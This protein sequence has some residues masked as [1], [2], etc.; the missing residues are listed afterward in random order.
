MA[1]NRWLGQAAPVAQVVTLTV[2]S[3]TAGHTFQTTINGKTIEYV[4]GSGETTTTIAT[5]IQALLAAS[6]APEF[7]EVTWTSDGA[8]VTGTAVTAGRP[9]TVTEAGT[10]TYTLATATASSGP[11]HVDLAANWSEGALPSADGTDDILIDGPAPDLLWGWENVPSTAYASVKILA[12]F[13]GR[14]GLPYRNEEGGYVE[15]R[16]R[17]F[18]LGTA[19]PVTIGE[20]DGGGPGLVNLT[21]TTA[22]DVTVLA[23]GE[24]AVPSTPAV[25]V[26]GMGS[27]TVVVVAG[28]VGVATDDSTKFAT[29]TTATVNDGASLAVGPGATVTTL[30][31]Y[32]GYVLNRGTTTTVNLRGGEVDH[33][34]AATTITADPAPGGDTVFRWRAAAT[35]ATLT[36]RGQAGA[37]NP[38]CDC[39]LDPRAKTITNGSF[40]GGAVLNDPDNVTTWSNALTW[41]RASLAASDIGARFSLLKS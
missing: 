40:T 38:V 14:V 28:D 19:T 37:R 29:V 32:G 6:D 39:S 3:A 8:V 9:F 1:T 24:R 23:T 5:A 36:F 22:A 30:N 17:A 18:L 2:G 41:D 11:N 33:Y 16:G 12:S 25:N 27:G 15:Y 7:R 31:N 35:I 34:G 13:E 26:A 10:G 4:A 20:G 21:V